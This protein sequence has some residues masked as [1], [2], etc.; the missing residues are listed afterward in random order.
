MAVNESQNLSQLL[1]SNDKL[2]H[3]DEFYFSK[4]KPRLVEQFSHE[5][6]CLQ[7]IVQRF[8]LMTDYNVPH[9][10][11]LRGLCVYESFLNLQY[12]TNFDLKS[13]DEAKAIGWCI[14]FVILTF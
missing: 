14:E 10:K 3:F 7:K 6:Q 9:G 4:L 12:E 2:K 8:E 11:K 5:P 1:Y 13:V